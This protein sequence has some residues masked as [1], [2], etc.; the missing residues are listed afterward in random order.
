[1]NKLIVALFLVISIFSFAQN[2]FKEDYNSNDN[3]W[4]LKST[5]T[6]KYSLREGYVYWSRTGA[7]SKT[8]TRY[9]NRLD[10]TKDFDIFVHV[11]SKK[12]GSEYGIMWGGMNKSNAAYFTVKGGKFRTFRAKEGKIVAST[13]YK[14]NLKIKSDNIITV[15]KKV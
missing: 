10:D 15:Q 14:T 9:M 12:M 3:H 8:L 7:K 2:V 11:I 4:N 13:D 1:M 6:D 5:T